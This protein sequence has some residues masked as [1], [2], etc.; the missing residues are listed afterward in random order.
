MAIRKLL[1]K[2]FG[3]RPAEAAVVER[4]VIDVADRSTGGAAGK[5]IEAA[6]AIDAEVKRRKR[7]K[8]G[9]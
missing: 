2:V 6:E 5:V 7:A 9:S 1:G 3:L 4:A 8:R